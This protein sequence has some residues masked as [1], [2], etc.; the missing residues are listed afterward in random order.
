M[1]WERVNILP[2]SKTLFMFV[3]SVCE[4]LWA[5][6]NFVKC[7]KT[8]NYICTYIMVLIGTLFAGCIHQPKLIIEVVVDPFMTKMIMI[9]PLRGVFLGVFFIVEDS[10]LPPWLFFASE[11]IFPLFFKG[12]VCERFWIFASLRSTT[13]WRRAPV[14]GH[15][16]VDA[17]SLRSMSTHRV[18]LRGSRRTDG[19]MRKRF[20]LGPDSRHHLAE[21]QT[22]R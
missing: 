10:F 21:K 15:P 8:T 22:C 12:V 1:T 7:F 2:L 16:S 5:I 9:Y 6:K 3:K 18:G 19:R 17:C 14:L 13:P 11:W 20:G 4:T